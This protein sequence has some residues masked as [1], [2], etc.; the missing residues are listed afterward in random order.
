MEATTGVGPF[1]GQP[2]PEARHRTAR[3]PA[4]PASREADW[5]H[6]TRF[7]P[8]ALFGFL[9]ML[10]LVP[11][12]SIVLPAGL[13]V[14]A[15]LD[16][17]LLVLL[18]GACLLG[19]GTIGGRGSMRA[20]PIHWAF[21]TFT[22]IATLSVLLHGEALVRVGGLELAVK[23]LA[24]LFSYAVF[25]ALAAS[26]IRP[27][28]VNKM[29]T[30]MVVLACVTAAAL[31]VEFRFGTNVF[32]DWIGPLFPG[33]VRPVGLGAVD[34]IGRKQ[35]F[36]PT[37]QPLAASVMVSLALPFALTW[38]LNAKR[39]RQRLLYTAVI[40]LLVGG[41]MATQKKTSMIAPAVVV[42]VLTIYRPRAMLRLLP[43][44]PIVLIGIVH[45]VAPGALGGVIDQFS[46]NSVTK[47]NSTKDRV[48]DYEAVTPDLAAHPLLGRG[49]GSYDQ[50]H[51]RIL[52]NQ[53]L[54]LGI[55][56][57]LLGLLAY[58]SILATAF[59]GAHRVTRSGD[60]ERAPPAMGAAAAIVVALLAGALLDCLSFP[61][62][63]YVFCFVAAIACVLGRERQD[64]GTA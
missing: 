8:W 24:L 62:L 39:N 64:A 34:S 36:G 29:I 41:A 52:D 58:L 12:D 3:P 14:E 33:Y 27:A 57:G 42:L 20:S 5:P 32:H 26:I 7:L 25:F 1:V 61:Q 44:L 45:S 9:A 55:G 46:P 37:I 49:Y 56:V 60:P 13:P 38:L 31:I 22:A 15:T 4:I 2:A 51:H 54:G 59:L 48:S 63:P 53:Y 18:T 43:L 28:E 16:R 11:F 40:L 47:V 6:T 35:I 19:A 23:Q 50:K 17:P 21:V 10:W 30:G